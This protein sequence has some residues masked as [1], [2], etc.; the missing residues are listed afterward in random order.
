MGG[1]PL[2]WLETDSLIAGLPS[3]LQTTAATA[4]VTP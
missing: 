4:S 3:H 1:K 2:K